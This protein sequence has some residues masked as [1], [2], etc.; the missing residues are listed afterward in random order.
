[1]RDFIIMTD[2]CCDLPIEYITKKDIPFVSLTCSFEG[3]EY[4][5]DFGKSLN[6]KDFYKG[7]E[8]GVIP[9]TSQPNAEAFYKIFK[10][11]LGKVDKD[12]LYISVSTGLSG[13]CNSANIAKN[14]IKE[15]FKSGEIIIVD[16]LTASL[17]Q[18]LMVIKAVD[19]KENGA[20]LQD[21]VKYLESIKLNL[22][23]YITV[24]DLN[25]LKR[26][27]R[28][29]TAAALVGT[30][31]HVKPILTLN[32]EG[33]VL[34][35]L[36]VKGRKN[37]INTLANYVWMKIEN[38]E[39]EIISICHGD[40][41]E[42]AERLKEIILSKIKVKDIVLNYV[43]PVI[44]TYGGPGSLSVFF[45]GKHRQNHIVDVNL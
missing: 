24:N 40:V 20:A 1:M 19:M 34:P 16:S 36:K 41:I 2:S 44:G 18:G 13:T 27:G 29:S 43:G 12:I 33:K 32:D 42:E 11:I 4:P 39:E 8:R 10:E 17:G 9:K 15:E 38:S 28:I 3:K 22:N 25:H 6:Y 26:G 45:T 7:M 23:T 21:I 35:V 30:I 14:M 5:D 31:L 37:A